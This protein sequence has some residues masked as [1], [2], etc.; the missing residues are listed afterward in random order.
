MN[1]YKAIN[2]WT[3]ASMIKHIKK[4][5]K[6]QSKDNL[7]CYYRGPEGTKCA[8]G[9]FIPDLSYDINMDNGESDILSVIRR[10][11][12]LV[13]VLPLNKYGCCKLQQIHDSG[14]QD[15]QILN[16]LIEF[17]ETVVTDE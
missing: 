9:M 14:T 17:I 4:E 16:N 2:G 8:I 3:K 6:G 1:K 13:S 15:K 11:P 12:H 5:F 10:N 7:A